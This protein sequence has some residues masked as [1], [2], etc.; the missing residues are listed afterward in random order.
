MQISIL[1]IA[2]DKSLCFRNNIF[3]KLM[4]YEDTQ[5]LTDIE[6]VKNV[7]YT[8]N[9]D[10]SNMNEATRRIHIKVN[11]PKVKSD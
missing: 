1:K 11:E 5:I 8:N 10:N 3:N 4:V 7:H 6:E 2:I 9:E